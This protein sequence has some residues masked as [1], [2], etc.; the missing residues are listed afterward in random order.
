MLQ[1]YG[2]LISANHLTIAHDDRSCGQGG[3][4]WFEW[5]GGGG[6]SVAAA[7]IVP[8]EWRLTDIILEGH[9]QYCLPTG[10]GLE[11]I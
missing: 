10:S 4:M 5:E 8:E 1:P 6:A 7:T 2:I 9:C 11:S 3:E